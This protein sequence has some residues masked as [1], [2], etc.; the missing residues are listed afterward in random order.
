MAFDFTQVFTVTDAAF[1]QTG[2]LTPAS[3]TAVTFTGIFDDI[4]ISMESADGVIIPDG[5][6]LVHITKSSIS[7]TPARGDSV[8]DGT[9]TYDVV[10]YPGEDISRKEWILSTRRKY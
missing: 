6:C 8:Y 2:T 4:S 5:A 7:R 10:D 3:G 1:S 9:Y